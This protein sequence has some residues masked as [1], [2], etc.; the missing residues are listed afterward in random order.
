MVPRPHRPS[1]PHLPPPAPAASGL[2]SGAGHLHELK[3]GDGPQSGAS[4]LINPVIASQVTRI[5]KG[6]SPLES[7]RRYSALG[8][9]IRQEG[10]VMDDL[11]FP[12][13]FP[14]LMP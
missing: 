12:T 13:H 3:V 7:P 10:G 4:I 14:V 11:K 6:D 8:D 2:V 1:H 9:K 5:L